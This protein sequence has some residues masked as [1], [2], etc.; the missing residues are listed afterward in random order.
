LKGIVLHGGRGTRLRPL[1]H[2]GPKQLIPVGGKAISQ[3]VLEDLR[4]AGIKEV[5]IVLGNIG[6]ERVKEYYGDGSRIGVRIT[7]IEQESPKGIADAVRLCR[8][9]IGNDKFIVFLGDNLLKGGVASYAKDFDNSG[10]DAMLLLTRVKDPEHFGV[11]DF[12]TDGRLRG[13][14]EKPKYAPSPYIVT[15]IYFFTPRIFDAI[16]KVT[17][18]ARGELEIT[19]SIQALIG[20][21]A[22]VVY[23]FVEGWWKDTGTIEDIL[24]ANRLILD[25]RLLQSSIVGAVEEGATVEGRVNIEEG[26][27]V[28]SKAVIRGP[29]HIGAQTIIGPNSYI[30]PYTSIGRFC[31]VENVEIENSILFDNCE[32]TSIKQRISESIIG[33]FSKLTGEE[34]RQ[35]VA[36]FVIGESSIVTL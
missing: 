5:A 27:V 14:V 12:D 28:K 32:V 19:D 30:G 24:D 35:S 8:D 10:A 36:H 31:H 33:Q 22:K 11:A 2:T 25:E 26:A 17:P 29:C 6:A 21:S 23:R 1:T 3:Y 34:K 4:D 20:L 15:G 18:S 13:V 16:A 9:F 7:Y